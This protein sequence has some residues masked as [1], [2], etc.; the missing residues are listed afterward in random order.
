GFRPGN[1]KARRLAP[2]STKGDIDVQPDLF[3]RHQEMLQQA[4][5]AIASRAYWSPFPESPSPRVYGEAAA[6]Q[7]RVAFE[8]QLNKP[9]PCRSRATWGPWAARR[10]PT[11]LRWASPIRAS[12]RRP[13]SRRP[14]GPARLGVAPARARGWGCA[15]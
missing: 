1:L 3:E 15:W 4:L 11:A 5:A 2:R 10:R 13:W 8:A 12:R 7:G 9:S 14:S 6:E